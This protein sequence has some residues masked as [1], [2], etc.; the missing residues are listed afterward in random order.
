MTSKQASRVMK[1]FGGPRLLQRALASVGRELSLATVYRWKMP[2]E[3][4]GTDGVIPSCNLPFIIKAAR[5]N[6]I[7]I[8][9]K[10]L[11]LAGENAIARGL[12]T[13]DYSEEDEIAKTRRPRKPRSTPPYFTLR[14]LAQIG[15]DLEA[16]GLTQTDFNTGG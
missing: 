10:D 13:A 16:L 14:R 2:R 5:I 6:G 12:D 7:I 4:G 8:S 15:A 11:F 3:K 9:E 1:K